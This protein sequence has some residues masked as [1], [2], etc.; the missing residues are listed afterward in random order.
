MMGV[1]V[2]WEFFRDQLP[3][4]WRA[5]AVESGLIHELPPH[6]H[7][8][9]KDIEPVLRLVL[10]RAGLE[11]SLKTTTGEAAAA[12]L[13]QLSGV[14]LH[15][16]ERKLAPYLAELS[17]RLWEAPTSFAADRWSG[18]DVLAVDATVVTRPGAEGTT[19]RVHQVLRLATLT[20]VKSLV[21]DDQGGETLRLHED[22]ARA[23]QLWIA[24]RIYANPPG[25]AALVGHGAAVL[26][27]YNR[28]ALPLYDAQGAPF[29]VLDHVRPLQ[30]P[31]EVA[32]WRVWVHPP[33]AE[34]L[35]GRLCALRLADDK[36]EEARE[37][38]RRE[39]GSTVSAAALEAAAWILVFTTVPRSRMKTRRVLDLYRLRWQVELEAK[40]DKS[41]GG[42]DKLPN[43]RPDTIATWLQA[44][45]LIQLIAKKIASLAEAFPPSVADWHVRAFDAAESARPRSAASSA[46]RLRSLARDEPRGRRDPRRAALRPA[47]Q[48]PRGDRAFPRAPRPRQRDDAAKA[49][50]ALPTGGRKS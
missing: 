19:A 25:I 34:P 40:R 22:V 20:F 3:S 27:R 5:L 43:F 16:W 4:G 14:A 33:Q 2:D 41:L 50:G 18:Y 8:K 24:D 11:A 32:E 7:T 30:R 1:E 21:T 31:G 12:D 42:L 28:G 38:L 49:A 6:L 10:H 23:G 47:V 17:A 29:D 39:H 37:R 48:D 36:A 35:R 45:L 15:K 9:V 44:K 46:H 26:V 13:I